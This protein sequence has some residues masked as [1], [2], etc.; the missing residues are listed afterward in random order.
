MKKYL[1]FIFL[2]FIFGCGLFPV[3]SQQKEISSRRLVGYIRNSKNQFAA[4]AKICGW[5]ENGRSSGAKPFCVK[6]QA[7]GSFALNVQTWG[8]NTYA[9]FAEYAADGI[10]M[11]DIRRNISDVQI[12]NLDPSSNLALAE[13][14][15]NW[16]TGIFGI[17]ED[18]DT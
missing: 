12:T 3:F 6:S 8:G 16:K 13:I 15:L 14:R 18:F 1:L 11:E 4:G 9:I 7:D 2:F 10:P 5:D 17:N